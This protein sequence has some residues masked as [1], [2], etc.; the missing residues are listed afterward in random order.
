[1]GFYY[2]FVVPNRSLI[3]LGRTNLVLNEVNENLNSYV[4]RHWEKLCRKAV[5][6]STINGVTYNIASRW[7]G[8]VSRDEMIEIDLV[9][10]SMD[11]KSILVGECKW[12]K[13]S[14]G[15]ALIANLIE[16]ANKLLF[17]KGKKIIPILFVK[18]CKELNNSI[19]LPE[20]VLNLTTEQKQ[21]Y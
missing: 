21:I 9:A 4:S 20:N 6:G 3:E 11:K 13:I 14:N 5:S 8:N 16:K 2:R 1:L 7:W 10:Q 18:E 17:A 15:D 19:L 12:S